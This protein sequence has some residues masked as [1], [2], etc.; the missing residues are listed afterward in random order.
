[1]F[2][3]AIIFVIMTYTLH[4]RSN[5]RMTTTLQA[6]FEEYKFIEHDEEINGQVS[7]IFN[8]EKMREAPNLKFVTIEGAGKKTLYVEYKYDTSL[9]NVIRVGS[10]V[11]KL[12]NSDSVWIIN[13]G[14]LEASKFVFLIKD[15][16]IIYKRMEE[17]K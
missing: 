17:L 10:E 8:P 1:M 3:G 15:K 7:N 2:I 6:L 4:I 12:T 16:N 13:N 14:G 9:A 5:K 11:K